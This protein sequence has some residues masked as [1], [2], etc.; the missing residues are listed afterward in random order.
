MN[1]IIC[2]Y[3]WKARE[4]RKIIVALLKSGISDNIQKMNYVHN[5]IFKDN[6][7]EKRDVQLIMIWTKDEGKLIDFLS[8]NF[9]QIERL[10]LS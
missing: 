1:Y 6:K 10:Y 3:T 8:K 4:L 9:P 7:I 5:Y 2:S